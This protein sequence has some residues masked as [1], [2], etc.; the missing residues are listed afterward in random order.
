MK[1]D[2]EEKNK[3]KQSMY[4]DTV[5]KL[6]K[7]ILNGYSYEAIMLDYA[8]L[9]DRLNTLLVTIGM[10]DPGKDGLVV[11]RRTR[12][13]LR[14]LLALSEKARFGINKISVKLDIVEKLTQ[15]SGDDVYLSEVHRNI[16]DNIG[17]TELADLTERIRKWTKERNIYVHGLMNRV[18]L[19]CEADAAELAA[20]GKALFRE[21]DKYDRRIEKCK[22]RLKYR[23]Q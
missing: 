15:Y 21:M 9:E 14:G 5:K 18:P 10:A 19:E 17:A 6:N 23:I 8:L 2:S 11:T 4:A 22:I 12:K 1:N 16:K 20:K 3:L 13:S 7:A